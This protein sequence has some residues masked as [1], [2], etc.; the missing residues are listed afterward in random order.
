[1]TNL[2]FLSSRLA[3]AYMEMGNEDEAVVC[4]AQASS[5]DPQ[6]PML[7]GIARRLNILDT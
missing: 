3:T 2:L 7:S 4:Y 5:L 6:D 1:M